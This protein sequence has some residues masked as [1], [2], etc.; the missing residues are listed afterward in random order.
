MRHGAEIDRQLKKD[1]TLPS[2]KKFGLFFTILVGLIAFYAWFQNQF[3]LTYILIAI[4]LTFLALTLLAPEKLSGLNKLWA[5]FGIFMGRIIN[6]LILGVM[7]FGLFTPISVITR[8]FGRD[9]LDLQI[10]DKKTF[11]K[12]RDAGIHSHTDFDRQF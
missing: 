12:V 11:W 8:L 5:R 1:V 9:E 4:S 10:T 7:F 3:Q 2:N 6:P